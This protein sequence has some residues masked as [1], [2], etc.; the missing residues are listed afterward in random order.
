MGK[1]K[2]ESQH[3]PCAL[4]PTVVELALPQLLAENYVNDWAAAIKAADVKN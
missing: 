2:G 4:P 3:D 1:D